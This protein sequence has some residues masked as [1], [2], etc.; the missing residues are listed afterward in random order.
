M[1]QAGEVQPVSGAEREE[2]IGGIVDIYQRKMGRQA[3]LFDQVPGFK[4]TYRVLANV[5]TSV[6]RIALTLGLPADTSEVDLVRF[7]RDYFRAG[8]SVPPRAVNTGPVL[9]NV[10]TGDDIDILSIPTPRWHEKASLCAVGT[11]CMGVRSD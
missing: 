10:A 5:L 9:E 6:K 2:E 3:L 4:P 1:E 7:W 8:K 11:G